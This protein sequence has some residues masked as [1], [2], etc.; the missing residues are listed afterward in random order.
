MKHGE[1][2]KKKE[3]K[4][5]TFI[6][7]MN[8]LTDG[9]LIQFAS[10]PPLYQGLCLPNNGD[11]RDGEGSLLQRADGMILTPSPTLPLS[12]CGS[13]MDILVKAPLPWADPEFIL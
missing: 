5:E 10:N 12:L 11:P 9:D 4:R 2:K 1:S 6:A 13:Q 3:R 7:A 8:K